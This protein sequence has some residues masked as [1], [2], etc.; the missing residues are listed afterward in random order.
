METMNVSSLATA[1]TELTTSEGVVAAGVR[2]EW[3]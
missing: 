3:L 1:T 2:A